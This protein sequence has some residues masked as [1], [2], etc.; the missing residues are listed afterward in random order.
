MIDRWGCSNYRVPSFVSTS[1][2][3]NNNN[4]N[5]IIGLHTTLHYQWQ[6]NDERKELILGNIKHNLWKF[7]ILYLV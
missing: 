1:I 3:N 5:N 6:W 4:N 2:Q 7:D